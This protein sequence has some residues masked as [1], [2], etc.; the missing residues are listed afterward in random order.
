MVFVSFSISTL[1]CLLRSFSSAAASSSSTAPDLA[2]AAADED[3][4]AEAP[5]ARSTTAL[6]ASA[7]TVAVVG[8]LGEGEETEAEE[9]E[10]DSTATDA[11]KRRKMQSK[12]RI[13]S[14]VSQKNPSAVTQTIFF[15][16]SSRFWYCF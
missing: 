9:G 11:G 4:A 12:G 16:I 1:A 3:A 13:E 10:E 15:I 7:T 6:V 5:V 8:F 14:N 2:E